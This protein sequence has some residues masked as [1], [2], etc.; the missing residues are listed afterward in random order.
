MFNN[1]LPSSA[2]YSSATVITPAILT[3][4]AFATEASGGL[5]PS[6]AGVSWGTAAANRVLVAVLVTRH[7]TAATNSSVASVLFGATAGTQVSGAA[8][9]ST[10]QLNSDIWYAAVPS[11]TSGTI[12]FVITGVAS[13]A[14]TGLQLYSVNTSTPTPSNGNNAGSDGSGSTVALTQSLII[15]TNGVGIAGFN[16]RTSGATIAW[17][18]ATSDNATNLSGSTSSFNAAHTTSTGTVS[19]TG[20]AS[21]GF[22]D[23]VMSLAAWGP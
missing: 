12:S 15:P 10:N 2:I 7:T 6:Y 3:Y 16:S 18:N 20:T 1:R 4:Q 17:T 8:A 9:W 21:A 5:T 13:T 11:G 23:I 22:S 19:V 14:R